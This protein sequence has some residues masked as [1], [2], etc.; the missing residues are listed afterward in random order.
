MGKPPFGHRKT[1]I[2]RMSMGVQKN[3]CKLRLS[4]VYYLTAVKGYIPWS[5]CRNQ[6]HTFTCT[7]NPEAMSTS[8][9]RE[10]LEILPRSRSD[11]R[12]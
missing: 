11:T 3:G 2:E 10:N 7:S 4:A 9:S 6:T 1:P 8:A 5:A 12:G